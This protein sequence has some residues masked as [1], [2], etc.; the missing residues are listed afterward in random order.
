MDRPTTR[1]GVLGPI[2]VYDAGRTQVVSAEIR[3]TL[4][5]VL[6][7]RAGSVVPRDVLV[8]A[9]WRDVLPTP[10]TVRWHIHQLRR[11]L[12][13]GDRLTSTPDGY[14]L[15]VDAEAVDASRFE[16]LLAR[17]RDL[18]GDP[19][20]AAAV[21]TEALALWR[22]SAYEGL[23][24]V[25][26]LRDEAGRLGEE[27]LAALELRIEAELTLGRSTALVAELTALVAESPLH[28]G[29]RAQ[30]MLALYRSGRSADALSVYRSGKALIAE[31]LGLD[32]GERLRKLEHAILV[33]DPALAPADGIR[34]L[35]APAE[36]PPDPPA[37][38]GR[39]AELDRMRAL[40]DAGSPVIAIHGQGGVGKSAL[41]IKLAH[42]VRDA[43]P[44]GQLYVD[45]HGATPGSHPLAPVDVLR[46]FLRSLGLSDD[47]VPGDLDEAAAR[48]R[49]A[50]AGRRM[51]I[52]LDDA[53]D[54]AQ[55]RRLTPGDR[56]SVVL[57]T[58]R[59]AMAS[60]DG[61][62]QVHLDALAEGDALTVLAGLA[63]P[64]RIAAEPEAAAEVV[65]LC[66]RLPLALRIAAARLAARPDWR[67]SELADRLAGD[68]RLDELHD[69]DLSVRASISV[70]RQSLG[71]DIVGRLADRILYTL[72]V[73]DLP[74]VDDHVVGALV[75]AQPADVRAGLDRLVVARL[76]E[77]RAT[78][79][80]GMH[81][82]VRLYATEVAARQLP[83]AEVPAAVRRVGHAYLATMRATATLIGSVS[84]RPWLTSGVTEPA[85]APVALA[86]LG[87][88][89]AWIDAERENLVTVAAAVDEPAVVIALAA[90]AQ[91]PF[92]SRG[93]HTEAQRLG[94]IAM[95]T[96]RRVTEPRLVATAQ[97]TLGTA[98]IATT[99]AAAIEPLQAAGDLF[100]T[101]DDALRE[102]ATR[103][104]LAHA[105]VMNGR[106]ADAEHELLRAID[107][108]RSAGAGEPEAFTLT[109]L[110]IVLHHLGRDDE[111]RRRHEE[112]LELRRRLGDN[113]GMGI[114]L[115][116]LGQ[117]AL[118]G[119]QPDRAV[120]LLTSCL[121][122][123]AD[124]PNR[125]GFGRLQ[126]DL[127]TAYQRLGQHDR[128]AAQRERSL[129][130]LAEH[131]LLTTAQVSA[132][133]AEADPAMPAPYRRFA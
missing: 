12:G 65:R 128:A 94:R 38:A 25:E 133:L 59:M 112:A 125:L 86:D 119:D 9:A 109:N 1:F 41:A 10:A 16:L 106:A 93:W 27:R 31:E 44:D 69:A 56:G 52:V 89:T 77:V 63:G 49:S 82:L 76:V 17:G 61:A 100:A 5:A 28:E 116:N 73:L 95:D 120:E 55:V 29:F 92:S 85:W 42:R 54:A 37:L 51:L 45:L 75:D 7:S 83:R 57:V 101:V 131:G 121:D 126:W 66:G 115:A 64:G 15:Q 18:A 97:Y 6:L 70:G 129:T 14:L 2:E 80:Y 132:L 47:Q 33:G 103:T 35:P 4:L 8:G 50:T 46:R 53:V 90:A 74:D 124:W 117:L 40:L 127:G 67:I 104:S 130:V 98:L 13:D 32:P 60:L 78:G 91:Q 48:F 30:L 118:A 34:V 58:S 71:P 111:A 21:L 23:T 3:R 72:P 99:P 19:A 11:L 88:A 108:D 122:L 68:R 79:R 22:G 87:Q 24:D 36:L 43:F 114:S 81:D 39:S 105:L 84:A 20:A 113:R 62:T 110:G 107:L 96:A 26:L 123:L 102:A